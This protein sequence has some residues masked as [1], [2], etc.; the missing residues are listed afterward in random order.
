MNFVGCLL[1]RG[2]F[3]RHHL[4]LLIRVSAI[5]VHLDEHRLRFFRFLFQHRLQLIQFGTHAFHNGVGLIQLANSYRQ[6]LNRNIHGLALLVK[7]GEVE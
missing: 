4:L 1:H 6:T 3:F 5:L 7:H 2:F